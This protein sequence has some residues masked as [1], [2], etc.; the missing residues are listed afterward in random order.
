MR[1][2]GCFEVDNNALMVLDPLV[3][4][5]ALEYYQATELNSFKEVIENVPCGLWYAYHI[6]DKYLNTPVGLLLT[7]QSY[8]VSDLSYAQIKKWTKRSSVCCA[9]S[10]T[11]SVIES[12][13]Y[14][15]LS[16]Y[17]YTIYDNHAAYSVKE[18]EQWCKNE[19]PVSP[20]RYRLLSLFKKALQNGETYMEG[21]LFEKY[22]DTYIPPIKE[23]NLWGI[24]CFNRCDTPFI[25]ASCIKNGVASRVSLDISSIYCEPSCSAMYIIIGDGIPNSFDSTESP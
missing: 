10:R 7:H 12:D 16:N 2:I 20:K 8:D 5:V 19:L 11:L 18:L 17:S 4:N 22:L 6:L 15:K 3:D 14:E 13:K 21:G 23:S 9:F 24:D 1:Y 25:K